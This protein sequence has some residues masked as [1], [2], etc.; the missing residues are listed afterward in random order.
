MAILVAFGI[1]H[2]RKTDDA[3]EMLTHTTPVRKG[4]LVT[5]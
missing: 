2:A 1:I 4:A 5:A 3:A